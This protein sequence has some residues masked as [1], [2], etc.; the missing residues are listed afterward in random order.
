MQI[1]DRVFLVSGGSSGLGAACVRTLAGAGATA[2]L[3][4]LAASLLYSQRGTFEQ[5]HSQG[6]RSVIVAAQQSTPGNAILISPWLYATPLAYAAYVERDLGS[7]IV[8]TGWLSDDAALVPRWMRTRPVYVVGIVFGS[9]PG[10]HLVALP[11]NPVIYR[12]VKN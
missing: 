9:V 10:Y 5:R 11:T 7:R 12:V 1:A 2:F 3:F 4:V 6:A 8:E